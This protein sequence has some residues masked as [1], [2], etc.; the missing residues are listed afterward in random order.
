MHWGKRSLWI[1]ASLLTAATVAAL[2]MGPDLRNAVRDYLHEAMAPT[3]ADLGDF[4][5]D[6]SETQSP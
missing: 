1:Y 6:R 2:A 5:H 4:L 3:V